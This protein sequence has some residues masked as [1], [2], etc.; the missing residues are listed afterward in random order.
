MG[1]GV[2]GAGSDRGAATTLGEGAVT[3]GEGVDGAGSGCSTA[4]M[5]SL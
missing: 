3:M 5:A 2:V 1:G 4:A